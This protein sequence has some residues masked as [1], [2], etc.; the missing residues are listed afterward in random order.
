MATAGGGE[1]AAAQRA[2]RFS[3]VVQESLEILEPIGG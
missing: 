2:I 3:D 1:E